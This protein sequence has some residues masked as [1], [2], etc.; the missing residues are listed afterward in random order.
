[1][2]ENLRVIGKIIC[3]EYF[4]RVGKSLMKRMKRRGSR[5][6]SWGTPVEVESHL[7]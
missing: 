1:M 6:I 3:F 7:L 4:E 5:I 2:D